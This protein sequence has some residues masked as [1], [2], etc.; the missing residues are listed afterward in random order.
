M[1]KDS[2]QPPCR[3]T[4]MAAGPTVEVAPMSARLRV[5]TA[6]ALLALP[7]TACAAGPAPQPTAKIDPADAIAAIIDRH[8]AADW[9]ARGI[10]PAAPADDAEFVR[11]VYL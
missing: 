8:I 9:A 11:R 3:L 5:A 1:D 7:A 2:R 4:P 6:L 10:K